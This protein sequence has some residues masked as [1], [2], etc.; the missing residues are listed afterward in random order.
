MNRPANGELLYG[1][2]AACSALGI[3][4]PTIVLTDLITL[5]RSAKEMIDAVHAMK[6]AN[7]HDRTTAA[8]RMLRARRS[9]EKAANDGG[10]RT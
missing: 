8:L 6:N 3:D 4:P 10:K 1:Y 2:M 7:E 5:T 9:E